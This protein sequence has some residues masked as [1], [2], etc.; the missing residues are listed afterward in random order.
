MLDANEMRA[1]LQK[2]RKASTQTLVR[3][4]EESKTQDNILGKQMELLSL[5]KEAQRGL[6]SPEGSEAR[7]KIMKLVEELEKMNEIKEPLKSSLVNGNWDLKWTTSDSILGTK[8]SKWRRPRSDRPI[9]QMIDA[10]NL[11][12]ANYEP[13]KFLWI[14]YQNSVE[15]VLEPTSPS[16]TNVIFKKFR[17]GRLF[18]IKAP[19]RARG[20][21]DTTYLDDSMRISRG[22]KGNI[23]V[24]TKMYK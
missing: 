23:F 13:R 18:S 1:Q 16:C 9:V 14:N 15:A 2:I 24:L 21:L 7:A 22:D 4:I 20:V 5:C 10:V 11:K 19:A 17:I 3:Y 8:R 12:A 6:A